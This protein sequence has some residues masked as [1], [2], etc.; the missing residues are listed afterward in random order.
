MKKHS[1]QYG[2]KR[3][4]FNLQYAERKTLGISVTP[5]MEVVVKAPKGSSLLKIQGV[6]RKRASWILKQQSFFLAFYPKQPAKRFVVGETHLYL[7]RQFRLKIHHGK[8]ESV[9]LAGKYIHVVCRDKARVRQLLKA[10]YLR[11]AQAKFDL[12]AQD[13]IDHFKRYAVR[14][15]SIILREMPK[16]WGS[17]TAKGRIILNPELIKAPRGCI[18]YVI[19]HELC[20]LVFHGHTQKFVDLQKKMFPD[21]SCWKMRLETLLA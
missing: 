1:I 15:T 12:Y 8:K 7:G 6:I 2:S 19:V 18:E 4:E 16:R 17:C 10:W 21:W 9:R 14:P 13:W 5:D 20:H 11:L 3:I